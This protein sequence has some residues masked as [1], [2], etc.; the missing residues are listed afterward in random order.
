MVTT[1]SFRNPALLAKMAATVD[2]FSGGRLDLGLGAGIQKQEHLAYGFS[3]PKASERIE[4]LGESAEILRS[5]WAQK[6]TTF[7][8]KHFQVADAACEP[9]PIQK[10]HPPITIGGNGEKLL[11]VTAQYAD[12]FDFGYLPTEEAFKKKMGVLK[13]QCE[14]IGRVFDEIE[15]SC[16]PTGQIIMREDFGSLEAAVNHLKPSNV[17]RSDF[18]KYTYIGNSMDFEAQIKPFLDLG[19]SYFMLFFLDLPNT[20]GLRLFAERI[21]GK[22]V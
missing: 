2:A 21:I 18:E 16:W 12:R 20:T 17:S 8:G 3:F 4:R 15:K 11:K 6:R 10:P 5:L 9:K 7:R 13:R 1:N 22:G 14:A 19:V